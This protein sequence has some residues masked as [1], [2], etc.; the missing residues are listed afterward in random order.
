MT[1]K[2][3]YYTMLGSFLYLSVNGGT[4]RQKVLGFVLTLANAI[5]FYK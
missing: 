3:F 2:I 5:I 1:Y 4:I